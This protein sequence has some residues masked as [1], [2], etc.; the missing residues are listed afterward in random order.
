MK[1]K[2]GLIVTDASYHQAMKYA[3]IGIIDLGTNKTHSEEV[4]TVSSVRDA[5]EFGIIRALK[6][7]VNTY[8]NITIICDNMYSVF[9]VRKKVTG[10]PYWKNKYKLIQIIWLPREFTHE[11]DTVSRLCV[12][13]EVTKLKKEESFKNNV[14]SNTSIADVFLTKTDFSKMVTD[15]YKEE[16]KLSIVFESLTFQSIGNELAFD[17]DVS[18]TELDLIKKDAEKII[19]EKPE[20]SKDNSALKKIIQIILMQ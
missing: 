19:K 9:N 6:L 7:Y 8:D 5:E 16:I 10:S 1:K 2:M 20:M 3:S 17:L 11:A 12:N 15:I 13:E 14:L 18:K 4:T